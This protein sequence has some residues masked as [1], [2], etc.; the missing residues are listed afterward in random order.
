ML[1]INVSSLDEKVAV[2]RNKLR[3]QKQDNPEYIHK[4]FITPDLTPTEQ[5]KNKELRPQL[6][7]MNKV[8]NL[9]KIKNGEIV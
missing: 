9:Y 1:I 6:A 3:L 8:A 2:L 7:E 5:K 4:V